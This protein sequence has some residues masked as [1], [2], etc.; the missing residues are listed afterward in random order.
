MC[1]VRVFSVPCAVILLAFSVPKLYELRK[2]DADKYLGIAKTKFDEVYAK[3]D[4]AVLK[5]E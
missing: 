1:A 2:D 4:D 3:V 5:S